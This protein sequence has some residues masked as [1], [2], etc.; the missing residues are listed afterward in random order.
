M[1]VVVRLEEDLSQS[2]LSQRIVLQVELVEAME[3]ILMCVHI[4]RVDREIVRSEMQGLEHLRQRQLFPVTE[5][6]DI[7]LGSSMSN[8]LDASI[9]HEHQDCVSFWT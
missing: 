2:R 8:S 4:K 3:G 6:D 1:D 7:L 9:H 5:D